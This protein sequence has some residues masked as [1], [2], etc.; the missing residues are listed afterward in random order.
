MQHT[1]ARWLSFNPLRS[2]V[3]IPPSP[4]SIR[5]G[6]YGLAIRAASTRERADDSRSRREKIS[7]A[8]YTRRVSLEIVQVEVGLI[9]NFCEIIAC[10]ISKQAALVDPAFEV[11][12]LLRISRE[13]G[14]RVTQILITH[15][16]EDHVAGLAEAVEATGA[17]VRCHPYELDELRRICGSDHEIEA[18]A[19]GARISIGSELVEAIHAPGHSP[20]CVCWYLPRPGALITGDVLYVGS[21]GSVSDPRAMFETLQRRI[22]NLPEWTRIYP[23]HDYGSRPTSTLGWELVHNPALAA[24][25]FAEFC[26]YKNIRPPA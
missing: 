24:A 8:D 5:C 16:H 14:W 9:Q 4:R 23:G 22:A 15:S 17:R 21:C 7:I 12:R 26:A 3:T 2:I 20:G 10:P 11:D 6:L 13:R 19:D 18:L 1:A 25:S